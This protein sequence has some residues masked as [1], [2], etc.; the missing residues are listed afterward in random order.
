MNWDDEKNT[1]GRQVRDNKGQL[2]GW[3][4]RDPVTG[5]SQVWDS[6]GHTLGWS[7]PHNAS[8]P[9]YT[10]S[11]KDGRIAHTDTPDLLFNRKPTDKR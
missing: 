5:N 3:V 9:G 6:K 4:K 10:L 11:S 2:I 7:K 8:G 1:L